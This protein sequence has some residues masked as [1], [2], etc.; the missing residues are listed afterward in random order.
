[1]QLILIIVTNKTSD[2][3]QTLEEVITEGI[4]LMDQ[5]LSHLQDELRK[6]RTGKASP[7]IVSGLMVDYYGTPTALSSIANLSAPDSRTISI[8]PWEKKMLGEI[9]QAIFKAN[10]GLTPMNDGEFVRIGIPPLTEERRIIL[11]KQAK[12]LG[13]EAKV[14]LRNAR[15][16]MMGAV[17]TEV[18]A[19]Y[20]EDA[21]K[22]RED[23]IQETTNDYGKKVDEH[24]DAREKDILKI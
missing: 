8:Q 24:V 19:G 2:M 7:S 4:G 23:S 20:P 18:K 13:E 22:R 16:K 10:L 14:S 5:A 15:H 11:V 6:I 21:G 3:T 9:E 1:M 17:K 12:A